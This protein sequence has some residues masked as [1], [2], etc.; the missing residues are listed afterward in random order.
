M[1]E[2]IEFRPILEKAGSRGGE[3]AELFVEERVQT[4]I[5]LEAGKLE[6]ASF[7]IV[8]GAGVRLICG[9][10]TR[11]AYTNSLLKKD[12][13]AL[14]EAVSQSADSSQDIIEIPREFKVP[15][16]SSPYQIE[17]PPDQVPLS[18]K[19]KL[20]RKAE[21]CARKYDPSI[22]QVRI[23]YFDLS[24]TIGIANTNGVI[25]SDRSFQTLFLVQVIAEK[26]GELQ[27]GYEPV[28]G[29]QGFE[30]FKDNP[31]EEIALISAKRA[32]MMLKAKKAP[33]GKMTVVLSSEA[34]GTMIHEAVGHGLEADLAQQGLSVYQNRLG[35]QVASKLIS[36]VD[37]ATLPGKR[38]SFKIDDEGVPGQRTVLIDKGV[39]VSYMY[40]QIE[41]MRAGKQ[42]TGNGRRESYRF[43]PIVR[44]SNTMI[45]PGTTSPEEIVKSVDRGLFVKKMGGGQVD[46]VS[47]DFI[48]E[49]N[50]GYLI[51]G[52]EIA[53]PVRGATLVG[54]GP[55]V[56]MEVDMVGNDLGFGIGTCGKDGQ[57]VPVA[58]AQPTL[59][60][61]EIIVGGEVKK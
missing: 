52:G 34:G 28:G 6:R 37:D 51:E 25:A 48:F 55:K 8:Q 11:Y 17:I 33:G 14:A 16:A 5:L 13:L 26:D 31:P 24:R 22:V 18:E 60:I 61:P 39:L 32:V 46:T 4:D 59:R 41:A 58:D 29:T 27:V 43:R 36:V 19:I 9:L 47:G 1:I 12:L 49:V 7:G 45:L 21:E 38:G 44:M 20:L 54:N 42:S 3:L 30:L 23:R 15:S 57:G 40:D 2:D 10:K 56:L 35:Q 50:E 53:E